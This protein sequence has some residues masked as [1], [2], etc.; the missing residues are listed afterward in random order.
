MYKGRGGARVLPPPGPEDLIICI[1]ICTGKLKEETHHPVR[2]TA[3]KNSFL[4]IIFLI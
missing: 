4:N 2:R 3:S 1:E